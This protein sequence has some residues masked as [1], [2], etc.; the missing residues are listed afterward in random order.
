MYIHVFS[1]LTRDDDPRYVQPEEFLRHAVWGEDQEEW[2]P[3]Q[4]QDQAIYR[5]IS[6][7]SGRS[8][9]DKN[10]CWYQYWLVQ[11]VSACLLVFHTFLNIAFLSAVC[12]VG[13][14]WE[15]NNQMIPYG[16]KSDGWCCKMPWW[17]SNILCPM[18]IRHIRVFHYLYI[19]LHV[20][21][22]MNRVYLWLSM[23]II[24]KPTGRGMANCLYF[25]LSRHGAG[26]STQL[27]SQRPA[28][29]K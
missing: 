1:I 19:I 18:L 29:W 15:T 4:V 10:V 12:R 13:K 7:E 24:V 5:M 22:G 3:D 16:R 2:S 25:A 9:E 26:T 11:P 8:M 23:Y 14:R 20:G 17:S 28:R 21:R 6:M 27:S